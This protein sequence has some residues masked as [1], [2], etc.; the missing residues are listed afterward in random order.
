MRR[1]GSCVKLGLMGLLAGGPYLGYRL[2]NLESS[3]MIRVSSTE[4]D[5]DVRHYHDAALVEP[6]VVTR[7]GR[8]LTVVISAEEYRRL[9]R[10]DR[11]VLGIEDFTDADIEA[12]RRADPSPEAAS[13]NHELTQDT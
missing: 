1:E 13:F 11:E 4:F 7:N 8:D 2:V 3:A 10:R 5:K 12:V 6:V 9:K